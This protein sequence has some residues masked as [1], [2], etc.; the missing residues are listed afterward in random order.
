MCSLARLL[1]LVL[2]LT[3]AT[4]RAQQPWVGFAEAPARIPPGLSD[5][6]HETDLAWGDLDLDGFVDLVVV[7]KEPFT[8]PGKRTN[9]LLLNQSGFLQDATASHAVGST[10][11]G[12]Q[13]FLT[14]TNDRD[15]AIADLDLDGWPDVV[16][17]TTVSDGDPKWLGHPRVYRNLGPSGSG[18]AGLRYEET[19]IPQLVHYATGQP[20]NPRFCAVAVGDVTGDGAPDLYFA[21]YDSSGAGGSQEPPNSDLDDRLLVNDGQGYFTD[22]SQARMTPTMLQSAFGMAAVIADVNGDGRNDIVKDTAL[23]SPQHVLVSYNDLLGQAGTGFFDV[24]QVAHTHAP[25]HVSVGDLN[26]DG[27]L[28]LVVTDDQDDRFRFNLGND[29]FGRVVWSPAHTFDFTFGGDDGFGG[30][31]L[32]ADLDLNGWNDVIVADVD[33]DIPGFSRR[34]HIY[35]NL[36]VP[37]QEG[38]ENVVLREERQGQSNYGW[39]GAGGLDVDDLRGTFDVAVFDVENDGDPDLVLSRA[40]GTSLYLNG[41]PDPTVCQQDLGY[42]TGTLYLSVCG[43]DLSAGQDATLE[44]QNVPFVAQVFLFVGLGVQP[45]WVPDIQATLVTFPLA[46]VIPIQWF[47]STNLTLPVPGGFSGLSVS[48]QAVVPMSYFPPTY[49]TS[50]AVLV[51]WP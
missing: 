14:P 5:S 44:L 8:T 26:K 7:R 30:N 31:N 33:V 22:Q 45:T 24:E 16:T 29:A 17:A 40:T 10:V 20:V 11:P 36:G 37:G 50:N 42:G 48:L 38:T 43:G 1:P 35:R 23:K 21:D 49:E 13:G 41:V 6:D 3:A 25:Y 47:G 19:R 2:L 4:A 32:I 51:T 15:V 28:D 9:V 46:A 39:I 18:W 12:D 34:A 27:R